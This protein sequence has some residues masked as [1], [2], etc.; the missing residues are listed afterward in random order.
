MATTETT[1]PGD[2][3]NNAL[4]TAIAF[5]TA[6]IAGRTVEVKPG[7]I[8]GYVDFLAASGCGPTFVTYVRVTRVHADVKNGRPGFGG[9]TLTPT[10]GGFRTVRDPMN[11]KLPCGSWGY[12]SQIVEVYRG[13]PDDDTM[14]EIAE[15]R[16]AA[17]QAWING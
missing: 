17:E 14:T 12:A 2:N 16:R 15:R 6:L 13:R 11:P 1:N 9:R 10:P 5:I 3:M 4:E 7:D 8:V